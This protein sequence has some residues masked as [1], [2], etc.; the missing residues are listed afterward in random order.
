MRACNRLGNWK[1]G[2]G[3]W[4]QAGWTQRQQRLL[5]SI[6]PSSLPDFI[7]TPAPSPLPL[8][9]SWYFP[10]NSQSWGSLIWLGSHAHPWARHW[11][12]GKGMLQLV[13]RTSPSLP[14][15]SSTT[16]T[17]HTWTFGCFWNSLAC[18][19]SRTTA[20]VPSASLTLPQCPH[21]LPFPHSLQVLPG[22]PLTTSSLSSHSPG[23]FLFMDV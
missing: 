2:G 3:D 8:A 1:A 17:L 18:R 9:L 12:Q 19:S 23:L 6:F 21:G 10:Q 4:L 14:P 13:Y 11:G 20:L 7:L 16:L 5:T 15:D 22:T